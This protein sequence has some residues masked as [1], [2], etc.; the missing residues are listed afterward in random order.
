MMTFLFEG[1]EIMRKKKYFVAHQRGDL[2]EIA[3]FTDYDD[4]VISRRLSGG[5]IPSRE[6]FERAKRKFK[7]PMRSLQ[8]K[9]TVI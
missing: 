9:K 1:G 6:F 4:F 8:T 3:K 7:N 2:S 5:N